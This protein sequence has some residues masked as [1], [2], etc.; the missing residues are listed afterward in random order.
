MQITALPATNLQRMGS[1]TSSASSSSLVNR[2]QLTPSKL[3]T[4]VRSLRGSE[5]QKANLP[6][7]AGSPSSYD[8][9]GN[10]NISAADDHPSKP[11]TP[12]K[13][14]RLQ[15]RTGVAS[16]ALTPRPTEVVSE[17]VG[18][19]ARRSNQSQST[20]DSTFASPVQ[21]GEIFVQDFAT[22][23]EPGLALGERSLA[24]RR[25]QASAD[26]QIP[27]SRSTTASSASL[28]LAR[29]DSLNPRVALPRSTLADDTVAPTGPDVSSRG[30]P[31]QLRSSLSR[32]PTA[33]SES[34]LSISAARRT[35][36]K[37]S[38]G[39]VLPAV[40]R[41]RTLSATPGEPVSSARILRAIPSKMAPPLRTSRTNT[42]S[43]SPAPS[44]SSRSVSA[45]SQYPSNVSEEELRG[46]EEMAAYVRRQQTK[47]LAAGMSAD[48][49]RKMFEFPDPTTPLPVLNCHD[50]FALYA[51]S[52]T[53]YEKVEIKEFDKI[54]FAGQNITKLHASK[55]A[56]LNNHGYDD[57]RGDYLLVPHDHILYRYEVIDVLGKG[58]FGQVLQC[59]DHCT[60]EMVAI[61]IIRN[62][63][64]F[65]HQ[66]LIEIK[67]LENLVK[68]VRRFLPILCS[69]TDA[70]TRIRM[71]ST[72]SFEWST[73][74]RSA[75]I[76]ASSQNCSA[77]I[78]TSLSRLTASLVSRL[79][80]FVDLRFKFLARSLSCVTIASSIAI[81]NLRCVSFSAPYTQML[82][83]RLQ[84][85][86]LK[87]PAKSAIKVIDFGSS[88]FEH[89]KG[90]FDA[91]Q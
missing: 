33:V 49:I 86:L 84:N 12:T 39:S 64:R 66:A 83:I 30:T 34:N 48:M 78:S 53:E 25:R 90:A 50:A 37:S 60:G 3:N 88:C 69:D 9:Y 21:V 38:E 82:L 24:T 7:I 44:D 31:G 6:T 81:S 57:D 74:S 54:Y 26:S 8:A 56:P 16:P 62:K 27:R 20:P 32:L 71:R 80:S 45:A 73:R 36:G 77:S 87:H 47:K 75:R 52:L 41:T 67:V 85:I 10:A 2:A 46:D 91:F 70:L 15:Y 59:R 14:P 58:S 40:R 4:P 76:F 5:T 29:E 28:R 11:N 51:R 22:Q 19:K 63:K 18:P 61:K 17:S 79:R 35:L 65:H 72:T 42:P 89:E 1:L 13:I 55:I 43:M 23:R 68:W